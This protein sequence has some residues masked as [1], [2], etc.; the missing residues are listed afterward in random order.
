MLN[1]FQKQARHVRLL[2][3]ARP[4]DTYA[5][6]QPLPGEAPPAVITI[7]NLTPLDSKK[8][9]K[10]EDNREEEK[11]EREGETEKAERRERVNE[12]THEDL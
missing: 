9:E 12:K 5:E 11:R 10:R 8:R 1:Q 6:P 2:L 7:G 3:A 4:S